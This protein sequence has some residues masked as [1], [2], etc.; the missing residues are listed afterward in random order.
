MLSVLF[1]FLIFI[2]PDII[3][4]VHLYE[5]QYL[6]GEVYSLVLLQLDVG[7][8]WIIGVVSIDILDAEFYIRIVCTS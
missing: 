2:P 4:A 1:L 7:I 8:D 3:L 5:A 6:V